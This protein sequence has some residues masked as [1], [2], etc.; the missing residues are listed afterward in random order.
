MPLRLWVESQYTL[1]PAL[2]ALGQAYYRAGE[3]EKAK[4]TLERIIVPDNRGGHANDFL[5]LAMT[6]WQLGDKDAANRWF[7]QAIEWLEKNPPASKKVTPQS[8]ELRV[9]QLDQNKAAQG[10]NNPAAPPGGK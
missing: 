8:P 9:L 2:A 5:L 7:D 4:A 1:Y 6:S 10:N 3:Y